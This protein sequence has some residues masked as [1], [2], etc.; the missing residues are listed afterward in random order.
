MIFGVIAEIVSAIINYLTLDRVRL[1]NKLLYKIAV[2]QKGLI[3]PKSLI[4]LYFILKKFLFF[5]WQKLLPN[6]KTIF[7]LFLLSNLP[8]ATLFGN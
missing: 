1:L 7:V 2:K 5:F 8:S 6:A 3:N 4:S